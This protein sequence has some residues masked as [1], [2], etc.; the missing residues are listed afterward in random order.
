MNGSHCVT[1]RALKPYLALYRMLGLIPIRFQE[2]DELVKW[3]WKRPGLLWFYCSVLLL[4]VAAFLIDHLLSLL[5]S[6]SDGIV[7]M[8]ESTNIASFSLNI[9]VILIISATFLGK[10]L[11]RL[12]Q[13][14]I[15]CEREMLSIGCEIHNDKVHI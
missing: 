3:N 2:T 8:L 15:R 10:R 13:L 6:S 1:L 5:K 7:G 12:V 4:R 14:M 9:L 11:C